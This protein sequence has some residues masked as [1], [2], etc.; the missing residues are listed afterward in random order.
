MIRVDLVTAKRIRA[1]MELPWVPS[2]DAAVEAAASDSDADLEALG[3]PLRPDE[4]RM[5]R[6][7]G[8]ALSAHERLNVLVHTG[9]PERF[10]GMWIDPPG[11]DRYVVAV[12][13][14]DPATLARARCVEG[15]N[16]N[17]VTARLSIEEGTSIQERIDAD[18][19]ALAV[20]GIRLASTSY[21]ETK[22]IV[23]VG[24]TGLTEAIR[25]LLI[26]RY[27]DVVVEEQAPALGL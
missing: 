7:G 17:Y 11:T 2:D 22:G 21:D 15:D 18:W 26:E 1:G 9:A 8:I 27:G 25:L 14:P 12:M 4:L 6:A 3:I 20:Q 5:I 16:T 24:V 19:Q 23:I 10:G 13:G